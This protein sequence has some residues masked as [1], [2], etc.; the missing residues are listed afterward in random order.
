MDGRVIP[1]TRKLHMRTREGGGLCGCDRMGEANG[2]RP[3]VLLT[4]DPAQVSCKSCLRML[5]GGPPANPVPRPK[6]EAKPRPPPVCECC[7]RP[8]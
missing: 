2:W 4:D 3:F 6:R 7:G 5:A 8:L 1:D